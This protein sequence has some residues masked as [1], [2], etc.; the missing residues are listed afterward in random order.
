VEVFDSASTR[1]II[2]SVFISRGSL[3]LKILT[4][5]V[6]DKCILSSEVL[7]GYS[8]FLV[9]KINIFIKLLKLV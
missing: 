5:E 8:L 7:K 2:I 3:V 6:I 4:L 9:Y 1:V